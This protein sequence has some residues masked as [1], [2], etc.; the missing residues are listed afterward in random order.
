MIIVTCLILTAFAFNG[1]L[2]VEEHNI[3]K[4]F[5][6]AAENRFWALEREI[7]F[8]LHALTALRALYLSSQMI[9]RSEFRE[10]TRPLLSQ[11][12]SIQAL[13]W[14]PLVADYQREMYEAAARKDGFPDFAISE[15]DP[16]GKMV[17]ASER[18]EYFPVY[19]VEPHKGNETALGFD[20]ASNRTRLESLERS[21]DTGEM[22][23]T[24]RITLVQ[25]TG[26]HF[27]FLVFLPVYRKETAADSIQARKGNLRG[28]VI[29]VF[30]VAD[31][32]EKSLSYLNPEGINVYLSDRSAP[33]KERFLYSHESK[34]K[35]SPVLSEKTDEKKSGEPIEYFRPL[36]FAN[37][38]WDLRYTPTPEYISSRKTWHPWGVLAVGL[39]LT[40]LLTTYLVISLN[41]NER[42]EQLIKDRTT[43]LQKT[44]EILLQ[45]IAVRTQTEKELQKAR[46]VLE[47]RVKE[48]T[49]ELSKSNEQLQLEN[50]ERRQ[51]EKH[52]RE[53]EDRYRDLVE[54]SQDLIATHDLEGNLL[55]VNPIHSKILGYEEGALRKMNIRDILVPELQDQFPKYLDRIK[56]QGTAKG[57]MLV[58]TAKGERR[59]WEFNNTLRKEGV[60]T[61][62]IR[63]MAHDVTEVKQAEERLRRSEEHFRSLIE[64]SSDMI[65]EADKDGN[66]RYASPSVERILGYE[67][68]FIIGKN[69]FQFIHP[70]DL[71]KTVEAY[72]DIM[73]TPG[74]TKEIEYRVKHSDG[75]WRIFQSVR[76]SIS[77]EGRDS[78]VIINSRDI[79]ERKHLEA[80][81]GQAQKL[82]AVGQLAAGIGHEINTP[83]QYIGDN[84]RFLNIAFNDLN[85]VIEKYGRFLEAVRTGAVVDPIVEEVEATI[86]DIDLAYLTDEIPKALQQTLEGVERVTTIV[87]AMKEFAHPGTK[88]KT[89]VD[90]NK[91]IETTITV[92][93]NEWK[94]VAEMVTDFEPSLPLVPCLPGEI[95]QAILNVITNAAHAIA[96]TVQAGSSGKGVIK[97]STRRVSNFAEIHISDTGIG[98]PREIRTKIFDPFFTTKAVGKGT[99]Q[100]LAI[101]R[102]VIVDKHHG[103]IGFESEMGKGTTFI[104]RLPIE[105]ETE[106]ARLRK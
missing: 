70:D 26:K 8:H 16:Q 3:R 48:R 25:E 49:A 59:I 80:Q 91:A 78:M 81:L 4:D 76:R 43:D 29:G 82:E 17:R 68:G 64:N 46:D 55:S 65:L 37:R 39:L 40:G 90:I 19:F 77:E 33:E 98:I 30:R 42:N 83:T 104:I 88:E 103:T 32:L 93:R 9:T 18:K 62:L 2:K 75:S 97:V 20:L 22:V 102:S 54:N 28:F 101:A 23:S 85:R 21:R 11:H 100:G 86:R 53:S 27:G 73:Q 96:D 105:A 13:E 74:I 89:L 15:R 66:I 71:K 61:P 47:M 31:I 41:R 34:M 92:S 38:Q 60:A 52:L 45:E 67:P 12:P 51:A 36:A 63:A 57:L 58:E 50:N 5:A 1:T 106:P 35:T 56:S 95:N 69:A 14:I 99:G 72:Q 10:F 87:R 94:Y 6:L 7:A 84:T 79:T 24:G 44:N